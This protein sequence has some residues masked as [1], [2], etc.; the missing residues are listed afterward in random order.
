MAKAGGEP[1]CRAGAEHPS[2]ISSAMFTDGS[3]LLAY[4]LFLV[5]RRDASL[6]SALADH[7]LFSVGKRLSALQAL[8]NVDVVER[9][10]RAALARA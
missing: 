5:Q 6:R 4:D 9:R 1:S 3:L 8:T 7:P 10:G 2:V